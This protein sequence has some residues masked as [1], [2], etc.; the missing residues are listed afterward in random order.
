MADKSDKGMTIDLT[1]AVNSTHA[2]WGMT[3]RSSKCQHVNV[4]SRLAMSPPA[5]ASGSGWE[6]RCDDCG[7]VWFIPKKT[8]EYASI[9][10]DG[11]DETKTE[12]K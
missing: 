8:D 9:G 10:G 6:C 12:G 2:V 4:W 3:A 11:F 7:A 1:G 5:L